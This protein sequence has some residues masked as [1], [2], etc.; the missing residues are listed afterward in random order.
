MGKTTT[1]SSSASKGESG[2][3]HRLHA[4]AK[5]YQNKHSVWDIGCDH[6]KLG[7]SFI[8]HDHV[9]RIHLVDPSKSVFDVLLKTI[10][11]Y[12]IRE[13]FFKIHP[14]FQRGQ[15]VILNP[16]SKTIFI[17]GMGGREI[18]KIF[19]N[20]F[21]QL[22]LEDEMIIS[23]HKNIFEL[24]SYLSEF[25]IFCP[26][27]ELVFEDNQYYQLIKLS[28]DSLFPKVSVYGDRIWE[29]PLGEEYRNQQLKH[30]SRHKDPQTLGYLSF[31]QSL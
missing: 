2:L 4:L 17:A 10:D 19:T 25:E 18:E 26:H 30:F 8:D 20:L 15:D 27:E 23:P 7:L 5:L 1:T 11:S 14:L 9:S 6:G 31:L 12:I 24:R 3:S 16:E 13:N 28:R 22:S 21:P 29:G